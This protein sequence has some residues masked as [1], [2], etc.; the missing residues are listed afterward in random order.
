MHSN[1]YDEDIGKGRYCGKLMI[2]KLKP[3][4]FIDVDGVINVLPKAAQKDHEAFYK[5][6]ES[7][8]VLTYNI[9]Y[10]PELVDELNRLSEFVEIIWLST[11]NG[12]A[13]TLLAPALGL[14]D[15]PFAM[16]HG[17]NSS[18]DL[19]SQDPAARW[20]KLNVI[21]EH[22]KNDQRPFIWTDD[23]ISPEVRKAIRGRAAFEGIDNLVI[24]PNS[25]IGLTKSETSM[26]DQFI[27][28]LTSK[29]NNS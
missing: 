7:T 6:W 18:F 20:W 16:S 19:S 28:R 17:T 13:A 12:H 27:Q 15:F 8:R 1:D 5:S 9:L 10:S 14:H 25:N 23:D 26:I 22:I 24:N 3:V 11:W 29:G 4:W 2:M 21:L